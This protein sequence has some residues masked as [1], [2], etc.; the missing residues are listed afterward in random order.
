MRRIN[1]VWLLVGVLM[2]FLLV[3]VSLGVAVMLSH[4]HDHNPD[5]RLLA[6]MVSGVLSIMLFGILGCYFVIRLVRGR[7]L[8]A[9]LIILLCA[10]LHYTPL[11]L[12]FLS[13]W[14]GRLTA[15]LVS[16]LVAAPFRVLSPEIAVLIMVL[17]GYFVLCLLRAIASDI[18]TTLRCALI[19]DVHHI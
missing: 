7:P 1:A 4:Q 11:W 6:L 8:L 18:I 19:K 3:S 17:V 9:V 16:N 10:S 13:S 12:G 14:H 2:S 5:W 15:G